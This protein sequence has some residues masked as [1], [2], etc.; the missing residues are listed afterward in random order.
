MN[1]KMAVM[2]TNLIPQD[3]IENKIL[4]FRSRKVMLDKDLAKLYGVETKY[5]KRQVHRNLDR[6]PADFMFQLT[7]QEFKNWRRQFVTS[8]SSDKMG[9][10]Y[11]PYAFTEPGIAMLSSVLNS[12]RAIQVNIQIIRTFIK[13]REI[14]LTHGELRRKIEAMERKY[15]QQFR[16][17]FDAIRKLL[18]PSEKPKRRI[19]FHSHN[20]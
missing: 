12:K 5:L 18:E 3:A 10:R 2:T 13:L 17:V 16:V 9:L 8:N 6:F 4:L 19:G 7:K 11:P 20:D 1:Q 14:L 15:D